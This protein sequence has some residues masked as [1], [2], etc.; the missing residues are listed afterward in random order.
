MVFDTKRLR[1]G[2]AIGKRATIHTAKLEGIECI[3]LMMLDD[4]ESPAN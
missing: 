4:N 2:V 1:V 3:E